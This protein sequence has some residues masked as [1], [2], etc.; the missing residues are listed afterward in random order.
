M[1]NLATQSDPKIL[2]KFVLIGYHSVPDPK[3]FILKI[4]GKSGFYPM[5][6]VHFFSKI[7]VIQLGIERYPI[8]TN[9]AWLKYLTNLHNVQYPIIDVGSVWARKKSN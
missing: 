9:F 3:A 8:N 6:Q 7:N 4:V 2:Q 1:V 5:C